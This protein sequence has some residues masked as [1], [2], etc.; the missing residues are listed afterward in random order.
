[1]ADSSAII[2]PK[3]TANTP[4]IA[5]AATALAANPA[6]GAW[7]IQNLGTNPLFIRLGSGASTTV[8][9]VVLKAGTSNDDGLG[10]TISQENGIIYTGIITIA[11]TSPRYVATEI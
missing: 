7:S 1:M 9:H 11:G 6:R 10:G 4:S 8:F 3:Q 5:S 2:C